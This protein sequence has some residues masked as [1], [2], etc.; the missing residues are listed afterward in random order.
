MSREKALDIIYK[1]IFDTISA[2]YNAAMDRKRQKAFRGFQ[3]AKRRM[4]LY[5][6]NYPD[7]PDSTPEP[8]TQEV[9]STPNMLPVPTSRPSP[10]K[11]PAQLPSSNLQGD[12]YLYADP[13]YIQEGDFEEVSSK[14]SP[15]TDERRMLDMKP[16]LKEKDPLEDL[17]NLKPGSSMDMKVFDKPKDDV[18]EQSTDGFIEADEMKEMAESKKDPAHDKAFDDSYSAMMQAIDR[19]INESYAAFNREGKKA[20]K[21][22]RLER[23]K[24]RKKAVPYFDEEKK[25]KQEPPKKKT[26]PKIKPAVKPETAKKGANKT[27]LAPVEKPKAASKQGQK[28]LATRADEL[29]KPKADDGKMKYAEYTKNIQN[30]NTRDEWVEENMDRIKDAGFYDV[31]PDKYKTGNE[32][33]KKATK[34]KET[35]RNSDK[36][37][38]RAMGL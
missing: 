26:E 10:P 22:E 19:G 1:G 18:Y 13:P 34:K 37:A 32:E 5:D 12:E 8:A 16:P 3:D 14:P 21:E 35:K 25:K 9:V 28:A 33:P 4:A 11:P 31:L 29:T 38:K 24:E 20:N 2:G 7:T 15:I 17:N 36:D 6:N 27:R 30:K 23:S